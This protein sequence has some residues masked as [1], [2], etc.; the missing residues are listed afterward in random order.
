[1]HSVEVDQP[2]DAVFGY[3][4][5]PAR[6]AEWQYDVVRVQV[7]GDTPLGK[8]ARFATTRRVGRSE[9]TMTQEVV[10][11]ASPSRWAARGVAGPIRPDA[12]VVVEPLDDGRRSTVTFELAF[13]GHG[14]GVPLLPAVRLMA[15]KG[16]PLSYR[17]PKEKLDQAASDDGGGCMNT[18]PRLR[19]HGSGEHLR[20]TTK[21]AAD[22]LAMVR[23]ACRAGTALDK[24]LG[25]AVREALA[26]GHTWPEIGQTL[27]G[28]PGTGGNEVLAEYAQARRASWRRFWGLGE[29][30]RDEG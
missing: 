6:F 12:R 8:G 15:A 29:E 3:V 25:G 19:L 10:E 7:D 27:T 2:P 20:L 17:R 1:V 22:P 13:R 24:A 11:M 16:A 28:G 4:T 14:I 30:G 21:P 23:E 26:A 5:D 18:R 9:R